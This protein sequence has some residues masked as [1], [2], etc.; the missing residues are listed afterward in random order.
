MSLLRTP[1]QRASAIV[2]GVLGIGGLLRIISRRSRR[3]WPGRDDFEQM[4][5]A[6][7]QRYIL[8]N[9]LDAKVKAAQRSS[10]KAS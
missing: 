6:A 9:G 2:G 5:D 8:S 7:F 3:T 1:R 4:D 10:T